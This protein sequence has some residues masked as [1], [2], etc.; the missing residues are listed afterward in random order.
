MGVYGQGHRLY[1]SEDFCCGVR[2]L[3]P[4]YAAPK[5]AKLGMK[6]GG[7]GIAKAKPRA[8]EYAYLRGC[9]AAAAIALW[10]AKLVIGEN[11]DL[12]AGED[13]PWLVLEFVFIGR[14]GR[15]PSMKG[16]VACADGFIIAELS[17]E[18]SPDPGVGIFE[19]GVPV[20]KTGGIP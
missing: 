9:E 4:A 17:F 5:V 14:Y 20:G 12:M 2:A 19:R 8:F 16:D 18:L 7:Y 11:A 6:L 15:C 1:G 3:Y 13:A 10:A